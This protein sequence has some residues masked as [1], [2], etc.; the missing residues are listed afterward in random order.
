MYFLSLVFI[1]YCFI[2]FLFYGI[3]ELEQNN[4][5]GGIVICILAII[6]LVFPSAIILYF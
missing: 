6:S 3:Y 2:K 4:K 5:L 1:L